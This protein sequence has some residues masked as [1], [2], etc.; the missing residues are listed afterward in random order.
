ME[1]L[2]SSIDKLVENYNQLSEKEIEKKNSFSPDYTSEYIAEEVKKWRV[3]KNNS[4]RVEAA[5]ILG[6]IDTRLKKLN[7]EIP[8]AK[9]PL[10]FS[11]S[12]NEKILGEMKYQ[13]AADYL[14]SV[15][16]FKKIFNEIDSAI[17]ID[18]K[19]YV[20]SLLNILES[21]KPNENELS[22]LSS[23][24]QKF[25]R[26]IEKTKNEYENKLQITDVSETIRSLSL[27]KKEIEGFL[28]ALDEEVPFFITPRKILSMPEKE[29]IKI[30]V[31]YL[32]NATRLVPA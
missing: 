20:S 29:I 15:K 5:G 13:R 3:E 21:T 17:P 12:D 32:N 14:K 8:K 18:D 4:F 9:Y 2:K 6:T 23:D 30:P 11:V 31:E 26:N 28:K 25:Y 24:E 27:H 7:M 16:D 1:Q 19:D 10:R 22:K